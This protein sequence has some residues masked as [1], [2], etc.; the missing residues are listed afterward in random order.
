MNRMLRPRALALAA[1]LILVAH[2]GRAQARAGTRP[3]SARDAKV[4]AAVAQHA[5]AMVAARQRIHQRPELGN[6]EKETAALVAEH[7]RGL[8]LEVKTGIA[9]TG[10]V[11]V[12]KGGRPGPLVAVRADMDALPVT[13]DTPFPFKSTKRETYLGQDVG[14]SHACGHDIHVAVQ[15]GVASVLASMKSEIAGEVQ[16][17][18]QPA[19]EGPPPGEEGGAALMV[20]EGIWKDRKPKAVFGLHASAHTPLGQ[21]DYTPGPTLSA[22]DG[23]VIVIKGRQ[24]HGARPDL[25]VDPIVVASEV[26][27]ALQTI[28]SRSTPPLSASV[29]TIGMFRGGQRRNIIPAEVELQGTVRTYDPKVQD[30]IERRMREILD[31]ITKAHGATY[32]IEYNRQYPATVNDRELTEAT[33]PS[34]KRAVGADKVKLVDPLT[35][36]EDFSFFANETPGFFYF[37]GSLKEGTTSGDHH[38]P[39]F[40]ADDGA[41]PVGIKA[42]TTVLLD[43][44]E[45]ESSRR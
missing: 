14:V 3:P 45:R 1:A 21:I 16:F 13:E 18:F 24:A 17:L 37:L 27:L 4:D 40:L 26:V 6:R 35:G 25:A 8:G 28:R 34:L 12:L 2:P 32:T 43:Y 22:A 38:T 39:T 20:K 44:L 10:V 42:M 33:L 23:V 9:Y 29:V 5:P 19:E 11:A 7:L 36:S 15:M 30:T 31:G 41:V